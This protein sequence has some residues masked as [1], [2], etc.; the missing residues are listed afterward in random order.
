[1]R[2]RQLSRTS[3]ENKVHFAEI[4]KRTIVAAFLF[5]AMVGKSEASRVH[6]GVIDAVTPHLPAQYIPFINGMEACGFNDQLTGWLEQLRGQVPGL[7]SS[8]LDVT[9]QLDESGAWCHT[10]INV[11]GG[12]LLITVS[13]NNNGSTVVVAL[14]GGHLT[15]TQFP[16]SPSIYYGLAHVSSYNPFTGQ[17]TSGWAQFDGEK[18]VPYD[19]PDP[20]KDMYNG[21][22]TTHC[23]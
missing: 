17:M 23:P 8:Q 11:G 6:Q 2:N 1:M 15:I 4:A 19:M 5:F 21:L 20:C 13:L 10:I 18:W 14:N 9:Y 3:L 22:G 12:A 7:T 16:N